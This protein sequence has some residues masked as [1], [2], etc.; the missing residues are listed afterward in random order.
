M[1]SEQ[2]ECGDYLVERIPVVEEKQQLVTEDVYT[3][4]IEATQTSQILRF[5]AKTLPNLNGI[6]HVKRVR[7]ESAEPNGKWLLVILCQ[8]KMMDR[9][10]LDAHLKGTEWEDSQISVNKVPSYPP[11]TR[12]QFEQWKTIWPVAYRPPVKLKKLIFNQE[13]EAYIQAC[14]LEVDE[15]C[16]QNYSTG[17]RSV[18][19]VIGN[20]VT[21]NTVARSTDRTRETGNPLRH[22]AMCCIAQVAQGEVE[23]LATREKGTLQTRNKSDLDDDNIH[24]PL[25]RTH[26]EYDSEKI[27]PSEDV[28]NYLCEGLDVF[29]SKEPCVMCTMALVHSR[30]GRLFFIDESESGGISHYSMHCIKALNHHFTAFKCVRLTNAEK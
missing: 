17:S 22:A 29:S 15:L 30:I 23:R 14:L 1:A 25:K 2:V 21:R 3:A 16:H 26:E 20:P 18:A 11:Y 4:R 28:A 27:E 24:L 7:R 6:E 10:K 12:D 13:E 5:A 19:V 9:D 8:C